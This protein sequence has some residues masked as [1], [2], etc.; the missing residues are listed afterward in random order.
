MLRRC[1]PAPRT[2]I[3]AA[4]TAAKFGL[5]S[6]SPGS[7]QTW[8]ASEPAKTSH[9]S[10]VAMP[11]LQRQFD[12]PHSIACGPAR[13]RRAGPRSR[14]RGWE[15]PRTQVSVRTTTRACPK[16]VA[17]VLWHRAQDRR[18]MLT[19]NRGQ[20][21]NCQIGPVAGPSSQ[22]NAL[23]RMPPRKSRA[24]S[25]PFLVRR[26]PRH[27]CTPVGVPSRRLGP[28]LTGV[29]RESCQQWCTGPNPSCRDSP[30]RRASSS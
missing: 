3:G 1:T 20:T 17:N 25:G 21:K 30:S 19:A 4:A 8:H 27:P 9:L 12:K 29:S 7:G 6:K 16:R 28:P 13:R 15:W 2:A 22:R 11:K 18:L 14:E 26:R 24:P 10:A 23:V 5:H